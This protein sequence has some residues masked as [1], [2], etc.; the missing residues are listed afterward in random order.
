MISPALGFG[1]KMLEKASRQDFTNDK[2]RQV[3]RF[4][5]FFFSLSF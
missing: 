5:A 2:T 4:G 1:P 3:G